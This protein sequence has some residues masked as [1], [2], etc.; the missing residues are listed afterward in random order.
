MDDEPA[1]DLPAGDFSTWLVQ[2]R[3]A[4][5][6]ERD[7]DV[8]CDGCT[9][10][11]RSSQFIPVGPEE[12]DALAHI[13]KELLF[14]APRMPDWFVLGYDEQGHCPML[15]DERCTVYE[16]RPVACRTYDCRVLPASGLTL[17][18][19]AKAA[20]ADRV[21]RWRFGHPT[22][23]DEREHE[24]VRAAATF[25]EDV[26]PAITER[27]VY[28]VELYERFLDGARP[29]REAVRLELKRRTKRPGASV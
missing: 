1:R 16:H 22:A 13:P 26:V 18:E 7:A 19:E 24:A 14:P 4:L 9:A 20:I 11:C 25:L 28:T 12:S 5:R 3:G 2:I 17:D 23:N 15:V 21:A 10:C 29:D 6:G 27:A 8:P